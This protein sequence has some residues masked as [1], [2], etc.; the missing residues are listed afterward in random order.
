ML[1]SIPGQVNATC[2]KPVQ[3]HYAVQ[4]GKQYTTAQ[5]RTHKAPPATSPV[6]EPFVLVQTAQAGQLLPPFQPLLR[7]AAAMGHRMHLHLTGEVM[8][9]SPRGNNKHVRL[10]RQPSGRLVC[11]W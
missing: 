1:G 5:V 9:D 4:A 6:N 3:I 8:R 7:Q 11:G 2:T 10:E